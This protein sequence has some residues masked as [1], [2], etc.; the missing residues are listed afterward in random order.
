[1]QHNTH[2]TIIALALHG[3]MIEKSLLALLNCLSKFNLFLSLSQTSQKA[4]T[5]TH[6]QI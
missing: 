3:H 6:P 5:S 2:F 4:G 1:M